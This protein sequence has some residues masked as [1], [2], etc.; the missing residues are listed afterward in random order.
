MNTAH[1]PAFVLSLLFVLA[2]GCSQPGA[3][4]PETYPVHGKVSYK[5]GQPLTGGQITFRLTD[6]PTLVAVGIIQAD[7]SFSLQTFRDNR[8]VGGAVAGE[9]HVSVVPPRAADGT[10]HAVEL[11]EAYHVQRQDNEFPIEIDPKSE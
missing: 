7:G 2:S 4:L 6:D 3:Q 11:P 5:A 10:V 1:S 9:H 8:K